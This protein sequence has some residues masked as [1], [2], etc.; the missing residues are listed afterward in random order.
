MMVLWFMQLLITIFL[1]LCSCLA[2]CKSHLA[3]SL[4]YGRVK[5]REHLGLQLTGNYIA[6]NVSWTAI[7]RCASTS[8]EQE[9]RSSYVRSSSDVEGRKYSGYFRKHLPVT[10]HAPAFSSL[11]VIV[12]AQSS[13][14][15]SR[16]LGDTHTR[17]HSE[18]SVLTVT[19]YTTISTSIISE[20][21]PR[22]TLS[23]SNAYQVLSAAKESFSRVPLESTTLTTST[24]NSQ[25]FSSIS[26]ASSLP[27]GKSVI[28]GASFTLDGFSYTAFRPDER[29][30]GTVIIQGE[31][32]TATLSQAHPVTLPIQ[33]IVSLDMYGNPIV[34]GSTV[35][36]HA[37]PSASAALLT[38]AASSSSPRYR[39]PRSSYS[40]QPAGASSDS[41]SSMS[42]RS[43]ISH[44]PSTVVWGD[45]IPDATATA[46]SAAVVQPE[47]NR[48]FTLALVIPLT[49]LLTAW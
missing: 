3:S 6:S 49:A 41:G 40:I 15:T 11:P 47:K 14:H 8:K 42:T 10:V 45:G 33:E 21:A 19:V 4:V 24:A 31:P 44:R 46:S 39:P 12:T 1:F 25:H 28:S 26:A 5:S 43:A 7:S 37:L 29:Y 38:S 9:Y 18:Q 23:P 20:D 36:L 22:S 16:R 17:N 27:G 48:R 30:Q 13:S 34:T 32:T 35:Y 2:F